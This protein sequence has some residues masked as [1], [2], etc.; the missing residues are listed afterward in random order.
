MPDAHA[1]GLP[2]LQDSDV[3]RRYPTGVLMWERLS[4]WRHPHEHHDRDA[5]DGRRWACS[6]VVDGPG[7]RHDAPARRGS[8]A[9]QT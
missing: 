9:R 2:T 1:E 7:S 6:P 5:C 8:A 3:R 4:R